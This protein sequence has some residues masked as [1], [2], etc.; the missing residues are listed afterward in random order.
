VSGN[1][2]SIPLAATA[3][4]LGRAFSLP[5]ERVRLASGRTAY[6]N[7]SA[8]QFADAVGGAI[9]GVVGLDDLSQPQPLLSP[10]PHVGA[11]AGVRPV[12]GGADKGGPDPC[13]TAVAEAA[14]DD[15]YTSDQLASAYSFSSL[16][17]EGDLGAGQTIALFEL[18]PDLSS[19]VAAYQACYGTDTSVS[20]VTVNGGVGSGAGSG[21]A[22]LDIEGV[23]GIAPAASI[24][25]YQ[26]PN[27]QEGLLADYSEIV[28]QDKANV[29]STSWGECE[30]DA[31]GTDIAAAENTLFEEAATQGQ[32]IFAAAGD[33]GSEGCDAGGAHPDESLAV[34]DP[35][36]QP[37]VTG[38]G[39][40]TLQPLGPP[41]TQTVWNDSSRSDDCSG[42]PC[43]G[44]GGISSIWSMPSYQT[45]APPWLN[46][47]NSDASGMPCG[48]GSGSYCRE[49][50]DVSADADP[51]T[52]YLIYYDGGSAG[53]GGTSAAA[54]LWAAF[55][56]LVNA[57]AA[58]AGSDIGFANP[59]LYMAA[60]EGYAT[61][62]DDITS[63][64]N[65]ITGSNAGLFPA[66]TGYDMAS[67]LG[68][69]IGS[70]LPAALCGGGS[71]AVVTV[72][73]PGD[74]TDL[75]GTVVQLPISASDADG[76]SLS[77][78]AKGLPAGLS[79]DSATGAIAGTVTTAATATVTVTT[80]DPGGDSGSATFTWTISARL[81]T[82]SVS[83]APDTVVA[84]AQTTCS[85]T[86]TDTASA[87]AITPSGTASLSASPG[88]G[89]F[90]GDG[91]CTLSPIA[92]AE[93]ASC[94]VAYTP[95]LGASGSL[96][97]AASYGGD[98]AHASSSSSGF[99]VIVVAD[100]TASLASPVAGGTYAVG[101][102]VTT[103][104]KCAE[105]LGGPGIATCLDSNGD[106][107]PG[108]LKTSTPGFYPYTVTAI[109]EDGLTETAS[110]SYAVAGSPS[111][112]IASPAGGGTYTFRQAVATAFSCEDSAYGTG[113]ASCT[114][115]RGAAGGVGQLDAST[116]GEHSYTVTATSSD[117]QTAT[118]SISYTVTTNSP[119][120][121]SPPTIIGPA[122][123]GSTVTADTG[124]WPSSPTGYTY[125]WNL[126]GTPIPGATAS[127]YT[128]TPADAGR[129]LT[130][131]VT[132]RFASGQTAA[133]TTAPVI[134]DPARNACAAPSGQ[135]DRASIGPL[136][137]GDTRSQAHALLP[138]Y[139]TIGYGFQNFCLIPGPG[140]R[141]A[142]AST[143][144]LASLSRAE[145]AKIAGR[146]VIAL[147]A[148]RHYSL[149]GLMPG[150]T[151]ADAR[152]KLHLSPGI[153]AG[154]NW[155]Y[156]APGAGAT[157]VL[158]VRDNIV[159][160]IGIAI[161]WLTATPA[162]Q[163]ALL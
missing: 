112:T 149:R 31:D 14:G 145:R 117:G 99:A 48:A 1:G 113:I 106:P 47:I 57:S 140:I 93:V 44:G 122:T 41:P 53:L 3:G 130:C 28:S 24:I 42:A 94:A 23:I 151:L 123:V 105:G 76:T 59:V 153:H 37:Y 66:G 63:G 132:A 90:S 96:V 155:W 73:N 118:A 125:R 158:K 103:S 34:D 156:F 81:T 69:P 135:I 110:I 15:A 25:V 84:G 68:S 92:T 38:V 70:S 33:E 104:F 152:R 40:T 141:V 97:V 138:I 88:N 101:Q 95:T 2:L 121:I 157:G 139:T 107:S 67:G 102:V 160:E 147:T 61:D 80:T 108:A 133:S 89:T 11:D 77:Y 5:L 137:L 129:T 144:L 8:P 58:C 126:D 159:K 43:G 114:D 161:A 109:S 75:A 131:T 100:P 124:V 111:V 51:H 128:L 136:V 6:A 87:T 163:R 52:G 54:P 60:S 134:P 64:D 35:A 55:T 4:A 7:T 45:D 20:Y 29:I 127:A 78:S 13:P 85:A 26:A 148:N 62:F 36:S 49:V 17:G 46:V 119:T 83:C 79:I 65:D 72:T 154:R 116:V 18:E 115:S 162:E 82:T 150:T 12:G 56:A 50:P 16:Y 146:L 71:P 86:V 9:Q 27:S 19:D 91:A 22:A 30:A 143:S 32:S 142:Y 39:G 98:G 21:E 120:P 74:Q 10:S